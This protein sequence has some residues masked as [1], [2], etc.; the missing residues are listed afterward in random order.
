MTYSQAD[1]KSDSAGTILLHAADQSVAAEERLHELVDGVVWHGARGATLLKQLRS[2]GYS[3]VLVWDPAEY[4]NTDLSGGSTLFDPA[5]RAADNQA[6][7]GV[8]IYLSPSPLPPQGDRDGV[9]KLLDMGSRFLARA[10]ELGAVDKYV[11]LPLTPVWLRGKFRESLVEDV[12][13]AGLP[14]ALVLA[15][16]GD[17]L[18]H[19]EALQTMLTLVDKAPSTFLL[20]SDLS[21]IGVVAYGAKY[22]AIG[23][24]STYRH[25]YLPTAR[26]SPADTRRG[27][28]YVP[29]FQNWLRRETLARLNPEDS[30][31][32][33]HCE[34]SGGRSV[35]QYLPE[36]EA[37]RRRAERHAILSWRD[38]SGTVL[39]GWTRSD[40]TQA[41]QEACLAALEAFEAT[42]DDL[43]SPPGYL[44]GWSAW[45]L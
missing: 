11:T 30:S 32:I 22:G 24:S 41:W 34:V 2:S 9:K 12:G 21:A 8:D 3:G 20:R 38:L 6:A 29:K 39:N 15:D 40:R 36:R 42:E 5:D 18:A 44:V 19:P 4:D 43:L 16:R 28:V 10:D 23:G 13:N 1:A 31:L 35:M 14:I 26:S 27:H 7:L 25:L 37:T 33:C 17:P 45:T